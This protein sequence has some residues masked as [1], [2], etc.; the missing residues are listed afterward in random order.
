MRVLKLWRQRQRRW[1]SDDPVELRAELERKERE[2]QEARRALR[3]L[4]HKLADREAE[5]EA[6]RKISE[7][8]GSAFASEAMLQSIAEIAMRITETEICH[9]F[10]FDET[11]EEL[12]LRAATGDDA[13]FINEIR[14]KPGEGITG[15]VAKE[16][17]PV[18]VARAAYKDP[19]FKL[20]PALNEQQYE[21]MLAVPLV[22]NNEVIGVISVRTRKPKEYQ[23]DQIR[24]LSGIA[25]H[26][27]GALN[28]LSRIEQLERTATQ[29]ATLSEISRTLTGNLYL[30]EVLQLLVHITAQTLGYK[31]VT[32]MLL[33]EEKGELVLKAT[34]AESEEYRKKPPLRVGESI[35]GRAVAENRVIVVPD[36]RA[37]PNY[38]FPDIAAR[39]G[40]H[41]MVSVP[42]R[43]REQV[44][45][46]LNCYTDRPHLFT[47]EELRTLEAVASQAALAIDH[48][49]LMVRSAILQEMH[50]RV[51][52]NLQQIAS[53]MRLQM[54]YSRYKTVEEVIQDSL[55]RIL[56]IAQVHELLS[57]E[58]L[59]M[60]SLRKIA[61]SILHNTKQALVPP[62]KQIHSRVEGEDVLLPLQ[63][64]TAVALILNELIQNA[65]EHGFK[66]RT[67]GEISV[68]VEFTNGHVL[69]EVANDGE[70][71]PPDFD[72]ARS[73]TLGVKIIDNLVRG[74]LRG[75]FEISSA[76]SRTVARVVF[77]R[78]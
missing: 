31:I 6:L 62:G 12:V 28:Q 36:V 24:L 26:L 43:V 3:Q 35:A 51:K 50:H 32:V 41:S 72:A 69:L 78:P 54:H 65:I 5:I 21:S 55:S 2:L 33:D 71:L 58:D 7:A 39:E 56:A 19:R 38:R 66:D 59:D 45:G 53:L 67:E 57:R 76:D 73:N 49:K 18:A 37:H 63:Q 17:R 16:R 48:A 20:Y 1:Q 15:W 68:R 30:E 52:N 44:I 25:S 61:S 40:L 13:R 29:V 70:P 14:L 27:A 11:R 9:I 46:V 42:L 23:Q 60:V 8:T 4:E 22:V 34:Q 64:A 10:L 75:R 74:T 77:P 47:D